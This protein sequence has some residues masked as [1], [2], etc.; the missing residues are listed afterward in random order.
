[1]AVNAIASITRR[2]NDSM[3]Q[4]TLILTDVIDSF[5]AHRTAKKL[6]EHS[7]KLYRR[8]LTVWKTWRKAH[9]CAPELSEIGLAELDRFFTYLIEEC[10]PHGDNPYRS[11]DPRRGLA[12]ETV[13]S[14]R[15]VL[16]ALWMFARARGWLK[17][18][19]AN[20]FS[21]DGVQI[22][23]V[24]EVARPVY[25]A[26]QLNG[27]LTACGDGDDETSARDRTLV[28]M[29]WESGGR[30]SEILGINDE[31]V[32]LPK[33]RA[34]I[35][36]KGKLE[37]WLRWGPVTKHELLRYIQRRRGTFGGKRPLFRATT[38][39]SGSSTRLRADSARSHIGLL[40]EEAGIELP[41]GSPFHAFRRS[42]IHRGID[43]G[44]GISDV[45]QL[46]G[47]R[48]VRTTMRYARRSEDRLDEIFEEGYIRRAYKGR[49]KN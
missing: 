12:P 40:M 49:S 30:I 39:R 15:R 24:P 26:D 14:F 19:Q 44:V 32:Q 45:S 20:F 3:E 23:R 16:R 13:A 33:N 29:L 36:G 10:I 4:S 35:I 47:H 5:L 43:D 9:Q 21:R 41:K 38:P 34:W 22:P 25:Q 46:A 42:F 37:R 28:A 27:M 11:A 48:D 17:P 1:M 2:V 6:A 8:K 18:E 31:G 7:L